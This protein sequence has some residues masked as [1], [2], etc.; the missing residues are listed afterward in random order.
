MSKSKE[1]K[2]IKPLSYFLDKAKKIIE[3]K[4]YQLAKSYLM[5]AG[6]MDKDNFIIK[7][8]LYKMAKLEND[9]DNAYKNFTDFFCN[10]KLWDQLT[11]P[12]SKRH[13]L[14]QINDLKDFFIEEMKCILF[15]ISD[16]WKHCLKKQDFDIL[17]DVNK[18]DTKFYYQLWKK[19]PVEHRIQ[20]ITKFCSFHADNIE[21]L[22]D[23]YLFIVIQYPNN[24]II[25]ATME[26]IKIM[27]KFAKDFE[28][29]TIEYLREKYIFHVLPVLFSND[30]YYKTF[31]ETILEN[32]FLLGV[33]YYIDD[34][35]DDNQENIHKKRPLLEKKLIEI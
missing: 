26:L 32:H 16:Q 21:Q 6:T 33:K 2:S 27:E 10:N 17:F 13:N 34:F 30:S 23:L 22:I 7:M 9:Y 19:F 1:T 29:K 5:T 24:D 14:E 18:S 15:S 25:Q 4:N 8:E 28:P 11:D 31:N 3:E 12:N 35:L 20:F